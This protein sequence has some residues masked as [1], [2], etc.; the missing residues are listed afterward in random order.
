MVDICRF[1]IRLYWAILLLFSFSYELPIISISNIDKFSLRLFDIVFILGLF[2][3]RN[4][5]LWRINNKI[6]RKWETIVFFM[7]I[8]VIIYSFMLPLK[9]SLFSF[10]Y[11]WKY[12]QGILVVRMFYLCRDQISF[13]MLKVIF[14]IMGV[15]ISV[16]SLPQYFSVTPTNVQL[17]TGESITLPPGSIIGPY[18]TTYFAL[19]QVVPICSLFALYSLINSKNLRNFFLNF[20]LWAFV[21]YPALTCG[22]RTALFLWLFSTFFLFIITRKF[23]YFIGLSL[24]LVLGL[25]ILSQINGKNIEDY[26]MENSY[27]FS[28]DEQLENTSGSISSRIFYYKDFDMSKYDYGILMPLIG[29]GFYISPIEGKYRIGYG[30]HNNYI[31][32]FEQLG[33]LGLVLFLIF[34]FTY[35]SSY[36]KCRSNFLFVVFFPFV[37]ALSIVSFSGQSFWRGFGTGNINTLIVLLMALSVDNKWFSGNKFCIRYRN[38]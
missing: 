7:T 21:S 15:F 31:F 37:L 11:L 22:S 17:V 2:I 1:N 29:S 13:S 4:S 16:Y 12:V 38:C 24:S 6:V 30:F 19:A 25:I 14:I 35:I 26:L 32:A 27:T 8:C 9:I 20:L 34:L 33:F 28:R 3:F 36:R 10:Y 18:N 5:I 23:N